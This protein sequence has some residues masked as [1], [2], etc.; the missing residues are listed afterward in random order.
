MVFPLRFE[1]SSSIY[2]S[3]NS[4]LR[5]ERSRADRARK[6]DRMRGKIDAEAK[7]QD[8]FRAVVILR[9][10]GLLGEKGRDTYMCLS[11]SNALVC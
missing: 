4:A 7:K 11:T 9:R 2:A 6:E 8:A 3:L 5:T 10:E 1:S